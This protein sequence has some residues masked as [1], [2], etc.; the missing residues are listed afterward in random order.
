MFLNRQFEIILEGFELSAQLY[1]VGAG[2]TLAGIDPRQSD[3]PQTAEPASGLRFVALLRA[4][5]EQDQIV[6][7]FDPRNPHWNHFKL[8]F[9][10]RPCRDCR[11]IA[12]PYGATSRMNFANRRGQ[13]QQ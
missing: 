13:L 4:G 5:F 2:Y 1:T 10:G 3:G 9:A 12:F 8:I 7:L 11:E 6:M